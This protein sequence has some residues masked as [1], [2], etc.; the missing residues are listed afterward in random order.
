MKY[1]ENFIKG[2]NNN[3]QKFQNETDFLINSNNEYFNKNYNYNSFNIEKS[4]LQD[5][6]THV[7][8]YNKNK[9]YNFVDLLIKNPN[10]SSY[11]GLLDTL[12]LEELE[13]IFTFILMN[14]VNFCSNKQSYI[15]IDKIISLYNKDAFI[16]PN[17]EVKNN[18]HEKIYLFL[19]SFFNK[20]IPSLIYSNNYI[21]SVINLVVKLGYPKNNFI[22]L[23]IEKEFKV[24]AYNRQGCILIQNLFPLGNQIQ[25]QNLFNKIISQYNDLIIDRYG[26]YL[27]KYLLYQLENGEK[28]YDEICNKILNEVKKYTKNK[29]SSVVIERLLDSNNIN[30]KNKIINK[31]CGNEN[32]IVEL[33]YHTY[34]NYVLQKII[35]VTKD[36]N[37]LQMI[38]KT[39]MK[40]KNSIYKLSYGKKIMKAI[41]VAYT[42]K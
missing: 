36:N 12:S 20:R 26:H 34:G 11:I 25:R 9:N 7:N 22:F 23:D 2:A 35:L 24:Y 41:S 19:F 31:I 15:L 5:N 14:M 42:L 29:Y 10:I 40:N 4:I 39:M 30:I 27:F 38:Y 16:L 13:S 21:S 28:Y 17:K 37:I 3:Y 6:F 32:D 1:A 18:L 33:L 8:N